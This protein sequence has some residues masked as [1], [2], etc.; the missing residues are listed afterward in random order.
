MMNILV[1]D[2]H[3]MT[4]SGYVESL[5]STRFSGIYPHLTSAF[6][7]ETAYCI[8]QN[9]SLQHSFDLAIM[10]YGL[11]AYEKERIMNGADLVAVIRKKMPNC[12]IIIITAHTGVL[13]V[14]DLF[15]VTKPDG[16]I[17]KN[18]LTPFSMP[19]AVRAVL[20]GATYQ[21]ESVET[22]VQ[23]ICKKGLLFD[24]TNRMILFYLS[25]GYKIKDLMPKV[26]LSMSAVQRR[27]AQMKDAF[28]VSD[29]SNLVR[30]AI[31]QGFI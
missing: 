17:I 31:A 28:N 7:C 21:S 19:A 25:K 18:D 2:D 10:D 4:V 9:Q 16:L 6:D 15:E 22:I 11:P 1:V 12:K 5:S 24:H 30:E 14:F 29:D 13:L 23:E 3:P 26:S 20:D 27:I 8:I